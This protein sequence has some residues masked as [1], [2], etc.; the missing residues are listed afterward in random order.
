MNM[1][2][3]RNYLPLLAA[4]DALCGSPTIQ[5]MGLLFSIAHPSIPIINRWLWIPVPLWSLAI[6]LLVIA[7][8]I[9]LIIIVSSMRSDQTRAVAP[10]PKQRQHQLHPL[11]A[12]MF[13][14]ELHW[15]ITRD[16]EGSSIISDLETWCPQ[17]KVALE[18]TFSA[19]SHNSPW[20]IVCKSQYHTPSEY[21]IYKHILSRLRLGTIGQEET[22]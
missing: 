1:K 21:E 14:V 15:K 12:K 13:G 8:A 20:C 4:F 22:E 3:L 17:C 18:T 5:L 16:H 7:L 10:Q 19:S 11:T 9:I 6:L 2:L